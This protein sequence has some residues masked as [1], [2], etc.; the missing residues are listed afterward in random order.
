MR[1]LCIIILLFFVKIASSQSISINLQAAD[2]VYSGSDMLVNVHINKSNIEG[3]GRLVV[4]V[5]SGFQAIEK[6][7][8]NGKFEFDGENV[9][10]LWIKMPADKTITVSFSLK[11]P[12]HAEG[13]KVLR[14]ELSVATSGESFRAEARPKVVVIEKSEGITTADEMFVEYSY[15]KKLGVSA[16]RQKPYLNDS[17]MVVVNI[18][19][20]KGQLINFG[21]IEESIPNNYTAVAQVSNGAIFVFNK[22]NRQVKFLWMNMP[23]QEQFI[24][25]YLLVP[26]EKIIDNIPFIITGEFMYAEGSTT[27]SAEINE[28]N[29]DLNKLLSK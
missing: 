4:K 20:N 12:P 29:V 2:K 14:G 24:V 1:F 7:S 26:D 19:I 18:L 6:N 13:F 11:I 10:I 5:P 21:K 25:S 22:A 3:F 15:I 28:R 9:K 27:K 17:N 16:I 8:L 23:S